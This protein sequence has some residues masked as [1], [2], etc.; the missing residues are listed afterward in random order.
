MKKTNK[1]NKMKTIK[2]T[3]II[4]AI[5]LISIISFFGMYTQN[6]NKVSNSVKDY[7]YAMDINGARTIKLKVNT[8][9]KEV[10]KDKDGKTIDSATD[11]EIEKNGYTK[12]NVPNNSED[13]LNTENYKKVKEV[14]EKR[15]KNM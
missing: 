1:K 10:I 11:E 14:I 13:I 6:K 9:T 4:L 5:I 15:L 8:D 12:E 7:Q 3:T 2:I